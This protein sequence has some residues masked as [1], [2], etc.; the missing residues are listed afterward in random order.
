MKYSGRVLI[1]KIDTAT[2]V[3]T[4]NTTI[5]NSG[6]VD[7]W[8]LICGLLENGNTNDTA[9]IEI[10]KYID[11]GYFYTEADGSKTAANLNSNELKNPIPPEGKKYQSIIGTSGS[12]IADKQVLSEI[13][14]S[15]ETTITTTANPILNLTAYFSSNSFTYTD[16]TEIKE[17][18]GGGDAHIYITLKDINTGTTPHILAI[19]DTEK[20]NYEIAD[21]ETHILKWQLSFKNT[22]T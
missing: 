19:A 1:S 6:T 21:N 17:L 5:Q 16:L 9:G 12:I 18:S 15:P 8:R 4:D 13:Q 14:Q 7:L 3:E 20:S 22:G 10:P 11:I 2:G